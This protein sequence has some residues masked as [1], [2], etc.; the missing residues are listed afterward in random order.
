MKPKWAF[1]ML[2]G[3]LLI[4]IVGC[5]EAKIIS[6]N[7]SDSASSADGGMIT[8]AWNS[9]TDSKS[10]GYKV[11]YG[12][13]P[14]EYK[15]CIDVG[16]ATESSPNVSKYTLTGLIKGKRYYIAIIA[17]DILHN[18]SKFSKEVSAEAK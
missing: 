11:C 13:S 18:Q 8:I 6:K 12:T 16:K 3:L 5:Q 7:S 2:S 9:S 14:G 17:Y 4:S 15:N 10:V 1:S